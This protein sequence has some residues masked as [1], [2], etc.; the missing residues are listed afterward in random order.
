MTRPCH[1]VYICPCALGAFVSSLYFMVAKERKGRLRFFV[2]PGGG[3]AP[4]LNALLA[5]FRTPRKGR[6]EPPQARRSPLDPII[7]HSIIMPE[8]NCVIL[9]YPF[10]LYCTHSKS[11]K[12]QHGCAM[13]T[14]IRTLMAWPVYNNRLV[15]FGLPGTRRPVPGARHPAH[16]PDGGQRKRRLNRKGGLFL[17]WLFR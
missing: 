15:K 4:R 3:S 9:V 17:V 14:E 2:A 1:D 16:T 13:L 6:G 8:K 10:F 11:C 5:P 7:S 12:R